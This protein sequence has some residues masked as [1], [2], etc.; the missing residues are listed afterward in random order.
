[1]SV[2]CG[3]ECTAYVGH[4]DGLSDCASLEL[5]FLSNMNIE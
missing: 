4:V 3:S 2:M 1:V 5:G